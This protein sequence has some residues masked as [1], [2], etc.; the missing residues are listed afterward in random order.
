M[1]YMVQ[2]AKLSFDRQEWLRSFFSVANVGCS[3]CGAVVVSAILLMWASSAILPAKPDFWVGFR[4]FAA[5]SIVAYALITLLV[6]VVRKTRLNSAQA[7]K[8]TEEAMTL[9]K[10]FKE[11]SE[12]L[13]YKAQT[14]A[15]ALKAAAF[16]L[17]EEAFAPFW[18]AIERA[19]SDLGDCQTSCEWLSISAPK[20]DEILRG[21]EHNF[22]DCFDGIQT[23]PDCRPLLEEF[24]RL[25]RL[26]QRDFRFANIWELRQTRKV[27]IAG[28]ATLGEAIRSL[29]ATVAR[30]IAELK[31]TIE[32]RPLQAGSPAGVARVA[33]RFILPVP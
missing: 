30:S 19:A 23:L 3:G 10:G 4:Y 6:Y 24:Y 1:S 26:A 16:E 20:Y 5:A 28:F 9:R 17:Q 27:L 21:R 14:A 2:P 18:D 22:P 8:R 31:N 32:T 33:L 15:Q 13:S 12:Y 25:V 11:H 29:E 7:R